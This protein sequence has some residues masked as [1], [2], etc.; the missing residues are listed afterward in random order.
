MKL[1][2]ITCIVIRAWI[3]PLAYG[4]VEMSKFAKLNLIQ[5]R[6]RLF[7][8]VRICAPVSH[9]AQPAILAVGVDGVQVIP[10]THEQESVWMLINQK[11]NVTHS[12]LIHAILHL[13]LHLKNVDLMEDHL[14]VGCS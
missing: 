14:L 8:L 6:V 11:E 5:E 3:I 13:F 1:A 7:L 9:H 12:L 4:A 2:L 10:R